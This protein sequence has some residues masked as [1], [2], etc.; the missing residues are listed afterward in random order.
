MSIPHK[1][2]TVEQPEQ[3]VLTERYGNPEVADILLLVDTQV[4]TKSKLKC[5]DPDAVPYDIENL[6]WDTEQAKLRV[7]RGKNNTFPSKRKVTYQKKDYEIATIGRYYP[8]GPSLLT[9]GVCLQSIYNNVVKLLAGPNTKMVDL[10]INNCQPRICLSLAK[11]YG[12]SHV[13][14]QKYIDDRNII[15]EQLDAEIKDSKTLLI[16]LCMGGTWVGHLLDNKLP[17]DLKPPDFIEGFQRELAELR[18]KLFDQDECKPYVKTAFDIKEKHGAAA[19]RSA[20]GL[21]LQDLESKIMTTVLQWLDDNK[22][23]VNTVKHDGLHIT[24][25]LSD[26]E[27]EDLIDTINEVCGLPVQF[28]QESLKPTPAELEW[29]EKHKIHLRSSESD[30]VSKINQEHVQIESLGADSKLYNDLFNDLQ[31]HD[32]MAKFFIAKYGA[33]HKYYNGYLYS[34]GVDE[35]SPNRWVRR[36]DTLQ[37]SKIL[38]HKVFYDVKAKIDELYLGKNQ[39]THSMQ[40]GHARCLQSIGHRTAVVKSILEDIK[41]YEDVWDQEPYLLAF[42]DCVM[43]LR[44]GDTR[45]IEREDMI[46]MSCGYCYHDDSDPSSLETLLSQI[47]P[48]ENERDCVLEHLAT[49]LVGVNIQ[50]FMI[51]TGMGGNGKSL[52]MS[53]LAE[54]LGEYASKMSID[55]LLKPLKVGACPELAQ[56]HKKRLVYTEEPSANSQLCNST[57]KDLTGCDLIKARMLYSNNDN[58]MNH[59]TFVMSSNKIPNFDAVDE[60]LH[61][62]LSVVKYRSLFRPEAEFGKYLNDEYVFPQNSTYQLASVRAKWRVPLINILI[63]YIPGVIGCNLQLSPLCASFRKLTDEYLSMCNEFMNWFNEQFEKIEGGNCMLSVKDIHV[64][65]SDSWLLN[66][67]SKRDRRQQTQAHLK[68]TL[69]EQPELRLVFKEKYQF[70]GT[71]RRN[72]FIGYTYRTVM[73][74]D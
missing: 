73:D 9:N 3:F 17:N 36:A 72:V 13:Y 22:V 34:I 2:F 64:A 20:M 59:A 28:K 19:H 4:C 46:S 41:I 42:D 61:R 44:T 12:T 43:D 27:I 62:R 63:R 5:I 6:L 26:E 68:M 70:G 29:F 56:I 10:D 18:T 1:L 7:I 55:I 74:R 65:Y 38:K 32:A 37:I 66:N 23:S 35:K 58:T 31:S 69:L 51:Q 16:R 71:C 30:L 57:I 67:M 25:E 14:L 52:L 33:D 60:A 21:L 8:V 40:M 24:R 49:G 53:L 50:K 15:R 45:A 48:I 39:T 54:T 47:F 11:H